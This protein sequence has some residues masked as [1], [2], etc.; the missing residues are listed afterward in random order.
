MSRKLS[1]LLFTLALMSLV[2]LPVLAGD[3]AFN[4][5]NGLAL[6]GYDPVSYHAEKPVKG[7][8]AWSFV[9][10]GATYRFASQENL[11]TFKKAPDRYEPAYGGWC[12]WAMLDGEKVDVDPLTY[13]VVDGRTYLFYNSFFINTLKKW[14]DRAREKGETSMIDQA[15]TAWKSIIGG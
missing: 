1:L 14:N 5:D 11:D 15:D 7:K 4:V 8:E 2:P 13:K 10:H 3:S 12:A 6:G 9:H